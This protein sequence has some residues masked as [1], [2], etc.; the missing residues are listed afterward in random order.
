MSRMDDDV[1]REMD[2]KHG[3]FDEL[4]NDVQKK[5]VQFASAVPTQVNSQRQNKLKQIKYKNNMSKK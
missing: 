4:N 3:Q 1:N 2:V 5:I